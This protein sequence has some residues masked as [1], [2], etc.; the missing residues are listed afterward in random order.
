MVVKGDRV[1]HGSNSSFANNFITSLA[2]G[3]KSGILHCGLQTKYPF[4][5]ISVDWL[6]K[7]V[8]VVLLFKS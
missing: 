8:I 5:T 3:F 6:L 2:N 4:G 1:E 7:F